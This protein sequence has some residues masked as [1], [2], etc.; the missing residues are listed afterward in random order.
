MV[1]ENQDITPELTIKEI[2]SN[3]LGKSFDEIFPRKSTNTGEML[4]E[5]VKLCDGTGKVK[6]VDLHLREGE[7]VGICGLVG[8]GKTELSKLLFG[9]SRCHRGKIRIRGKSITL[10]NTTTATNSRIALVP[11]E[12][13][14]EGVIVSQDVVS[15]LSIACID[16]FVKFLSF[17]MKP[18]EV[19]NA[20]KFITDL[21]ILTP[22]PFQ[23]V[24]FLSGGNQQ[25]VAIGKWLAADAD[26]YIMDEPTK[27]IDV[28]AKR[29]IF[30]LIYDLAAA[31]KGVLYISSE[32]SEILAVTERLYV[33]Y[34]GK[35]Q[36]ELI[37]SET[38]EQE[39][40]FYS[41]GGTQDASA[42]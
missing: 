26:V 31:K 4:F 39:I 10:K 8:A 40:M 19:K 42:I 29:E 34:D 38:S 32:I 41:T 30:D 18:A 36:K 35:I 24:K 3:M 22:S 17:V 5:A 37:T 1:V 25:K 16:R 28:G 14:K 11:E 27:G 20:E 2:V 13:R 6:E 23:K 9:A 15:N 12:R 33:M 7:I 21:G